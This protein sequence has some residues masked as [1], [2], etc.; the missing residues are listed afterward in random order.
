MMKSDI[1]KDEIQNEIKKSIFND[2][3]T[4]NKTTG[5]KRTKAINFLKKSKIENYAENDYPFKE[6]K[7]DC[8]IF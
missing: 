8:I 1:T 5:N 4:E 7:I 3:T 2:H 6:E